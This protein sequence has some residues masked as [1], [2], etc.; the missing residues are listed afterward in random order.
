[1]RP[2]RPLLRFF[3]DDDLKP[4]SPP[5]P[6][7]AAVRQALD[8][9]HEHHLRDIGRF[10][11]EF[12]RE[13]EVLMP[14]EELAEHVHLSLFIRFCAVLGAVSVRVANG[15]ARVRPAGRLG[16]H[17]PE[18]LHTYLEHPYSIIED[19]NSLHLIPEDRV[20][21]LEFLHQMELRRIAQ[22]RRAGRAP[23]I[24]AERPVAFAVFHARNEKGE[25]CYLFE[26]NEDWGRL[27][28]IGGKQEPQDGGDYLETVRREISEELGIDPGRVTLTRLNEKPIAAY[29]LLGHAGS[30]ASYPGVLFGACVEGPLPTRTP[31]DRWLTEATIRECVKADDPPI[32]VNPLYM[33]YLLAGNPSRLS[34]IPVST[35]GEVRAASV[36]DL[37]PPR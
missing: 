9:L 33:D 25:S 16:R 13:G 31:Q 29:G 34:R 14:V 1:M 26:T 6:V 4:V 5:E 17:V 30:L 36:R 35:T 12:G 23:R 21:A 28:L 8:L 18:I 10:A 22:E 32:M 37:L 15:T 3:T 20:S 11:E 24:L 2:G 19:W 27:N 7:D